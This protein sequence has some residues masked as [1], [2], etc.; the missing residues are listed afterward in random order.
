MASCTVSNISYTSAIVTAS[1]NSAATSTTRYWHLFLDGVEVDSKQDN[2]QTVTF[3]LSGLDQGTYYTVQ[4]K[5]GSLNGTQFNAGSTSF[6][7]LEEITYEADS[8]TVTSSSTQTS[9]TMYVTGITPRSYARIVR[10][11]IG[12][13]SGDMWPVTLPAYSTSASYTFTGLDPN[14]TYDIIIGIRIA[15]DESVRTFY[16]RQ[17]V[18]TAAYNH[19]AMLSANFLWDAEESHFEIWAY[20]SLANAVSY[21]TVFKLTLDGGRALTATIPAGQ[22]TPTNPGRGWTSS[23]NANETYTVSLYDTLKEREIASVDITPGFN[24]TL[25]FTVDVTATTI[26]PTV[27]LTSG[28]T[29]YDVDLTFFLDYPDMTKGRPLSADIAA[30]K[31]E[32]TR[33]WTSDIEPGSVHTIYLQDNMRVGSDGAYLLWQLTRRNNNAFEWSTDVSSGAVFN[34]TAADWNEFASQL[35]EK[36]IYFADNDRIFTTA[37]TGNVFTATMYNQV[38]NAINNISGTRK[39]GQSGGTTTMTTKSKGDNILAADIN[40]LAACLNE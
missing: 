25:S 23:I 5:Y 17:N 33:S 20:V 8:A 7:T 35:N 2:A 24:H 31:T 12:G 39:N 13:P 28:A 34:I 26:K 30:G 36:E 14:T 15:A 9:I 4:V 6:T 40:Q 22:K 21:D 18:S 37:T 16:K 27:V 19:V 29:S 38:V 32:C 3:Y 10:F 1:A 11:Q